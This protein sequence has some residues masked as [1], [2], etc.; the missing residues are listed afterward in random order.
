MKNIINRHKYNEEKKFNLYT[1]EIFK[2]RNI[3]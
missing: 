2:L 3:Y 1:F